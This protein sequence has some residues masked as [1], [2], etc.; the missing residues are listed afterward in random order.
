MIVT[1]VD[2]RIVRMRMLERCM[3]MRMGVRFRAIPVKIVLVLV[4]TIVAVFVHMFHWG[5]FMFVFVRFGQMQP[6]P[7]THE[8]SRRPENRTRDITQHYQ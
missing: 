4:M 3:F 8:R 7:A 5:V 2:V 1:V 6:N